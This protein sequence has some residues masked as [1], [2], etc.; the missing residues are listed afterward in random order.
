MGGAPLGMEAL[1]YYINII[2]GQTVTQLHYPYNEAGKAGHVDS[3]GLTKPDGY[4]VLP[5][6][7]SSYSATKPLKEQTNRRAACM[8][9]ASDAANC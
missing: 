5:Y 8:L 3:S 9:I 7:N 1:A 4:R 2:L 6:C